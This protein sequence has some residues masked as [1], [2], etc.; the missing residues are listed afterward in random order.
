MAYVNAAGSQSDIV[1]AFIVAYNAQAIFR[2]YE[3]VAFFSPSLEVKCSLFHVQSTSGMIFFVQ[4]VYMAS[5]HV[6]YHNE[7]LELDQNYQGELCN[8]MVYYEKQR[9]LL[10]LS[11]CFAVIIKLYNNWYYYYLRMTIEAKQ[12]GLDDEQFLYR[13]YYVF[14]T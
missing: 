14:F 5:T 13:A 9:C 4:T 8:L 11:Y 6:Y 12:N 10:I 7:K 1:F 2:F 3:L